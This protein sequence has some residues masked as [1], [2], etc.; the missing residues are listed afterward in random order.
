MGNL[1][2]IDFSGISGDNSSVGIGNLSSEWVDCVRIHSMTKMSSSGSLNLQGVSG[3]NSTVGVGHKDLGR[4]DSKSSGEN[5]KL[6]VECV[7]CLRSGTTAPLGWVT[8]T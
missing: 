6:H 7:E 4:A 1:G 3:D 5:Q 8:R 2:S